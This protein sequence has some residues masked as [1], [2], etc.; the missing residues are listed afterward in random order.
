ME[1]ALKPQDVLVVLKVVGWVN[2]WTFELLAKEIG[3]STSEVH[4]AVKRAMASEL[5][6]R[7]PDMG[8]L[9]VHRRNLFEFLVHGVRYA[10]PAE[11]GG[12][13]RGIPTAHA[14]PVFAPHFAPT[15][16]L[17][18]VW[19][20]PNGKTRGQAF[21]PLYRSVPFAATRDSG[22]YERLALV[23]A[24]RGGRARDRKIAGDMLQS[25]LLRAPA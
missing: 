6:T 3:M 18:P 20:D 9:T 16:E 19:P 8:I 10:F 4:S 2:A 23:D 22:L 15:D 17:P 13:G 11:R 25:M 5:V 1:V 12:V 24:I 14:A 21:A 7:R